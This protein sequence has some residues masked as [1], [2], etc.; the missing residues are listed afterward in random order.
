MNQYCIIDGLLTVFAEVMQGYTAVIY[1][2]L[3]YE[4]H[5]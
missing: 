4:S 5:Q 1:F 3:Y 2:S